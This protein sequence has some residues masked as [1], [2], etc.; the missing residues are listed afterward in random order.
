[1]LSGFSPSLLKLVLD[2]EPLVV[3]EVSADG[4]VSQRQITPEE[5][6][7]K[8]LDDERYNRIRVIL[9]Q[10]EEGVLSRYSF[11]PHEEQKDTE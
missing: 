9:S 11:V 6:L 3:E 7:R 2:G 8:A 4:T 1:M 10:S 5:T